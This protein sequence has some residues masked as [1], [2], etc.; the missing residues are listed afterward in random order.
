MNIMIDTPEILRTHTPYI[1]HL[2][3][4]DKE[5]IS[6]HATDIIPIIFTNG[7]NETYMVSTSNVKDRAIL[8]NKIEHIS[9][10][11]GYSRRDAFSTILIK[12]MVRPPDDRWDNVI[13]SCA[14]IC[15]TI[16]RWACIEKTPCVIIGHLRQRSKEPNKPSQPHLHVTYP[17]KLKSSVPNLTDY[18]TSTVLTTDGGHSLT[19]DDLH[20]ILRMVRSGKESGNDYVHAE[21]NDFIHDNY[22]TS[23]ADAIM[24]DDLPKLDDDIEY[25]DDDD[26]E[27]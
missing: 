3:A 25:D 2:F 13:T 18:L 7:P 6:T 20:R 24:H 19:L 11:K 15:E 9:R 17:T 4:I 26:D 22:A 14:N 8:L 12:F 23:Y 5:D 10:L 1:R 21:M 16:V 27:E